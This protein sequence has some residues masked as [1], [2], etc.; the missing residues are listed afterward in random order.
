MEYLIREGVPQRTAHEIIGRL[1]SGAMKQGV[2]LAELPLADF[3]A[4]HPSLDK[5]VYEVLGAQP[6]PS[7]HSPAT[8][9]PIRHKCN[10][11]S[12]FGKRDSR[13]RTVSSDWRPYKLSSLIVAALMLCAG[14]AWSQQ[15]AKPPAKPFHQPAQ[16]VRHGASRKLELETNP[17]VRAAV[18]L[19]RTEPKHY[20]SAILALVDLG[21]PELATPILKE[22]QGPQSLRRTAGRSWSTNSAHTACCNSRRPQP[23]HRPVSNLPTPA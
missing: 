21:R 6:A 23:S 12:A 1:V 4:A 16:R 15:P 17:A 3:Q 9:R 18:E 11:S 20:V 19:P 10:I 2:P 8:V 13:K 5:R 14:T 22:L 7:K